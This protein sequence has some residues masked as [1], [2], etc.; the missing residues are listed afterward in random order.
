METSLDLVMCK[1][2]EYHL[3]GTSLFGGLSSFLLQE[4]PLILAQLCNDL[5]GHRESYLTVD[6]MPEHPLEFGCLQTRSAG[7]FLQPSCLDKEE[8][9]FSLTFLNH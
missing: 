1:L 8:T 9:G 7:S 5:S 4:P 6:H 2:T 3:I